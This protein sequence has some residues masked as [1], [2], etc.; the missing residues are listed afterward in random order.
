MIMLNVE[1]FKSRSKWYW[2]LRH[3]NGQILATSE[4]YFSKWNA[5]RTAKKVGKLLSVAV[6][7]NW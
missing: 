5:N 7:E 1:L 2:R 6:V 3:T 4:S